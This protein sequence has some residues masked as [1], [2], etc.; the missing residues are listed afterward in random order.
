MSSLASQLEG[1]L[2]NL[3]TALQHDVPQE[4]DRSEA[5]V[6]DLLLANEAYR[7]LGDE[8]LLA[9]AER[10]L[11][12]ALGDAAEF[13]LDGLRTHLSDIQEAHRN[14]YAVLDA[15]NDLGSLL[16]IQLASW[17]IL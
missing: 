7:S 13:D 14:L 15:D 9:Q 17:S 3:R 10:L 8:R 5:Q 12:E 2:N 6:R 4:I 1:A 11:T 16:L